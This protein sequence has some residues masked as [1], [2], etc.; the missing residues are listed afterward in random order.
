MHRP[1]TFPRNR[2]F[3]D[4]RDITLYWLAL[5]LPPSAGIL[6]YAKEITSITNQCVNSYKRLVPGYE[7]PVYI[8]WGRMNR[9]ALVRVP[10]F[11]P[12]KPSSCRVEYRAPD[13]AT[14][15]YLCFSVMLGAGL[16][17]I[18]DRLILP[19]PIE[20]DIYSM[21]VER[22]QNLK[23]DILP[24]SLYAAILETEKSKLVNDIFGETFF[25]KYIRNKK[26][27]WENYRIQVTDYERK[28]YLSL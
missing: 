16:K 17:G 22:R 5:Q 21:S 10:A 2:S 25:S 1:K 28:R 24:D 15:P 11:K 9:S 12:Y 8:S 18:E 4:A 19:E 6:K 27:E 20:E 23:I 3:G 26:A 7:A 13:P 14:N